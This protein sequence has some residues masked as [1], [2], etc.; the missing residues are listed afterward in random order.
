MITTIHVFGI[1][2]VISALINLKNLGVALSLPQYTWFTIWERNY[3]NMTLRFVSMTDLVVD[4]CQKKQLLEDLQ[5][6][7]VSSVCSAVSSLGTS[8]TGDRKCQIFLF[9]LP[10]RILKNDWESCMDFSS[11]NKNQLE[12]NLETFLNRQTNK[13]SSATFARLTWPGSFLA[14]ALKILR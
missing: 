10:I 12:T 7:S 14:Y 4:T 3:K 11:Y 1:T 6:D 5:Q 8:P 13:T 2:T 9:S